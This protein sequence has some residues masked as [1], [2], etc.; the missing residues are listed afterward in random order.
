MRFFFSL[1]G[2]KDAG[3]IKNVYEIVNSGNRLQFSTYEIEKDMIEIDFNLL[4]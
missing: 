1:L 2:F 4:E 3:G